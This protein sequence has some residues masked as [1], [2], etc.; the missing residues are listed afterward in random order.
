VPSKDAWRALGLNQS[1]L[2]ANHESVRRAR[3]L[4]QEVV[5]VAEPVFGEDREILGTL[6]YGLST[7]RMH[8]AITEAAAESKAAQVN[9]IALIGVT[10]GLA[11]LLGILISRVQAVRITQP[12]QALTQ[13]AIDL[14]AGQRSV[15]VAI[16]SGDELQV[17]GS[18]FNRM[19]EELSNS[20]RELEEMNRTLEQK[21]EERTLALAGR[22]RDMRLVLDNV[23]QGFLT[24]SIDGVMASERSAVVG[25]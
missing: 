24:L 25:R 12:V 2:V 11:T 6:R 13:A 1:E 14:A 19:V 16:N 9:S 5:E 22:N 8:Q 4:K 23:D 17:L 3:R 7:R 15:R 10:V 18:S 21:V 20:Y